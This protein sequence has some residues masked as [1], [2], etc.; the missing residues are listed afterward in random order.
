MKSRLKDFFEVL[1]PSYRI[2]GPKIE[3]GVVILAEIKYGDIPAGYRDSQKPGRY[4]LS[5]EKDSQVF[6]FSSGPDSFKRFLN[7]PLAELFHF[8]RFET[9]LGITSPPF[10]E[11]GGISETG[12]PICFMGI[13]ACDLWAL[14]LYDRIFPGGRVRDRTYESLRRN[15]LIIAFNCLYPSGN[16][17]CLSTG[18]GPEVKDTFD[19]AVTELKDSF[20]LEEGS[21]RG[22]EILGL[23][24]LGHAGERQSLEKR[25]R[26]ETCKALF[27]KSIAADELPEIIFR[28]LDHPHWEDIAR[29]DLE[30][31]N[32]TQVCPT[33]FCNTSYDFVYPGGI[34]GEDKCNLELSGR[35]LRKWDSCFSRDFA[36]VHGGNFRLSRKARYRHWMAHKLAYM[37]DQFGLPGCV[38]C[39]RCI[40]WCPAGIDITRELEALRPHS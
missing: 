9:G 15:S 1:G 24:P 17:F 19:V 39:G 12:L 11:K 31:G 27:R 35:R 21:A 8:H 3:N 16:C 34:S 26:I 36:Q 2:I 40:T 18:T 29:R 28:N 14:K 13:R 22:K 37:Q 10:S 33:C 30:C 7:P 6:S 23:L 4:R 32:C 38:G 20:L 25:E 5:P